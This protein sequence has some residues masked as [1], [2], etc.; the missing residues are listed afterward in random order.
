MHME[1]YYCDARSRHI[2]LFRIFANGS[3]C[4]WVQDPPMLQS[5]ICIH[6]RYLA[7][8]FVGFVKKEKLSS[9]QFHIK[10]MCIF[11]FGSKCNYCHHTRDAWGLRSGLKFDCLS[12]WSISCRGLLAE[13]LGGTKLPTDTIENNSIKIMHTCFTFIGMCIVSNFPLVRMSTCQMTGRK[14]TSDLCANRHS[15]ICSYLS[16]RSV[17][18]DLILIGHTS[19]HQSVQCVATYQEHITLGVPVHTASSCRGNQLKSL[20][21]LSYF[22]IIVLRQGT[23]LTTNPPWWRG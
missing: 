19:T 22:A 9:C 11:I 1:P 8:L 13:K 10:H 7:L 12:V 20:I 18:F 16:N 21:V 17:K 4:L 2:L 3:S 23:C 6:S 5:E 14:V 15:L